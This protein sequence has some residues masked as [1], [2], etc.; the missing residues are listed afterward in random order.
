M[1]KN[2]NKFKL[3]TK[4]ILRE[5]VWLLPPK[6]AHQFW[7]YRT[8]KKFL[9]INKPKTYD[10]KIHWMMVNV[11]AK[12]YAKRYAKYVDKYLVRDYVRKCD[13]EKLLINLYGVYD[14]VEEINYDDFPNKF[15][16]KLTHGSGEKFYAICKNKETFDWDSVK[17]KLNNGLKIN[18]AKGLC[19]Y[20]YADVK[21]RIICEELL[22]DIDDERMTDYKILCVDGV[23]K[24]ILVC[25]NRDKGRDYFSTNWEKL[26]YV[27]EKYK[28]KKHIGKPEC[29]EEMLS[30]AKI[31]AKPFR[32][33]R[34]DFYIVANKIYFGEITLTPAAGNNYYLNDKGQYELGKQINISK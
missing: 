15:I 32:L 4:S 22:E 29:L 16:L 20:Q 6:V 24:Q 1:M 14:S 10:E 9:K 28:S 2:N 27:K 11:Y 17:N 5:I 18:F 30:Y 19:E 12:R 34:I 25:T 26:E 23:P 33:A 7:Y 8:H 31:L 21:P 13:L 3:F